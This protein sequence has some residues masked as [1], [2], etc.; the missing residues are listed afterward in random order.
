M[1]GSVIHPF[2]VDR[3]N[4]LFGLVSENTERVKIAIQSL[5]GDS[6]FANSPGFLMPCRSLL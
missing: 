2:Q 6:I 1:E 5:P 4:A 3:G